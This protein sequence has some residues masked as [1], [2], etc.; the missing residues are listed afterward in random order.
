MT[1]QTPVLEL[2]NASISY[3]TRAGEI[4]VVPDL[5]FKLEQGEALGL[6]GESG[7]GKSTVAFAVMSYLGGAGRLT[8]GRILF[9][10]RDMSS[11]SAA[12]LRQIRGGKMAMVYQDPM[13]SLNPVMRIGQQLIEVPIIHQ[14]AS[15]KE[16]RIRA[17]HML[18]EVNLPD[19]ESVFERY[20]HQLSGGQQ[21][22]VV[23]AMALMAEPSLLVMDEPTTG[24]DVTVEA[25]VLDLVR[26]LRQVH[27]SAIVFISHNLG[28]VV[29]ICD[30][31]GVMY[32]GELV[33]EGPISEV[34]RRPSHPY[35]RGLLNCIP[36]LGSD[37]H[38]TPLVPIP[39]QVPPA[40]HRPK[41]CIFS[42]R[43]A[44]V[45]QGR[46]TDH[47]IP[48]EHVRDSGRHRVQCV[49][50]DE[51]DPYRR[52]TTATSAAAVAAEEREAD[53]VLEIEHLRKIYHQAASIF[54]GE[55]G[56]DVKA[57]NDISLS[58]KR[59]TTLAIVGESGCGKSTLAKV[60]TG[61]EEAT[62]G[63]VRLEETDIGKLSVEKRGTE[64]K[65]K[66]Q[67]V[68][69]NPDSTLNPSHSVGYAISRSLRRLKR[70]GGRQARQEARQL[71]E[72]VKLPADFVMR[73]PRQLSGG[74]KQRVAIARAL[75]G[76]PDLVVADEPVSALDVSVQAAIINLLMEIQSGRD[77]TLLFISHDLSVVR[78]LADRVAVMYLGKVVEFGS[79]EDVFNPPYHPYTE[80]LLS[81]VPIPDPDLQQK[82]IILE[83]SIPSVT[84]IPKGC[85]FATRCPRKIGEICDTTPPPEHRTAS[86]HRILCH[87]PLDE[88]KHFEPVISTAAE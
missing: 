70:I 88:L 86:G 60:L 6:V 43:C 58:A 55:G 38:S 52:P 7:C 17:L 49:R 30:R 69:Q 79:V 8:S 26:R 29:R 44:Y 28:T 83:G 1:Q 45:V 31:I 67:M 13:S 85:P 21:Q 68:F 66:L 34:F 25:A 57:L 3:F 80:A 35:T 40:L 65:R 16:A 33:E 62:S 36:A 71:M 4:N 19:P 81:A 74:Q 32:A 77:A 78:Y 56:Y 73:K 37:K 76:D 2:Q 63:T 41:G 48:M 84:D 75:A 23:I 51:L 42:S 59:G 50:Y 20:P 53:S 24:L 22:R 47:R 72:T 64:I 27:N 15:K 54:G 11:M 82:R 10:G 18:K 87:I 14:G 9:E 12:E 46:C 5:S 39:G 61:L